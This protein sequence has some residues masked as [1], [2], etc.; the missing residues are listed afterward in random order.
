MILEGSIR[1][2]LQE[3]VA[4]L[5]VDEERRFARLERHQKMA[6]IEAT[7]SATTMEITT[8]QMTTLTNFLFC[9]VE[10]GRWLTTVEHEATL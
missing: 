8:T 1:V 9:M 3:E 4:T 7:M 2:E 6:A 5:A 10:W